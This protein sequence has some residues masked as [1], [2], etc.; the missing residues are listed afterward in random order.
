MKIIAKR[1]YI[2]GGW[3]IPLNLTKTTQ[4]QTILLQTLMR[5]LRK[6]KVKFALALF[7][8]FPEYVVLDNTATIYHQQKI[9]LRMLKQTKRSLTIYW[10]SHHEI[11]L[12]LYY[13]E[14]LKVRKVRT[15][16]QL[17]IFLKAPC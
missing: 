13:C 11:N 6:L 5:L 14:V 8:K 4:Q 3:I 16:T 10:L 1:R 17:P 15:C 9:I 7:K 12:L 2:N